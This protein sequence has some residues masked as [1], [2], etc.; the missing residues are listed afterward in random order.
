MGEFVIEIVVF[1]FLCGAAL[2]RWLEARIWRGKGDH[3]H[4]NRMAS[5]GNL[6]QVRREQIGDIVKSGTR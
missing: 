3:E 2:G 6:Y 5:G 4:M 1:A